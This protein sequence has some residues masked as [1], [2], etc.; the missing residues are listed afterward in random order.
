MQSQLVT[1][2]G[3]HMQ[4]RLLNN[5]RSLQ[6][7]KLMEMNDGIRVVS[8][9]WQYSIMIYRVHKATLMNQNDDIPVFRLSWYMHNISCC[10]AAVS[11]IQC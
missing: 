9:P 3:A 5:Y 2:V 11:S 6:L 4:S 1:G 8:S 7:G 10:S